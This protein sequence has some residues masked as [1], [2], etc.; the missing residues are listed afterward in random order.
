MFLLVPA[1]PCC[2]GQNPESRKMV[3]CVYFAVFFMVCVIVF[4]R[5]CLPY[6]LW[7]KCK[8]QFSVPFLSSSHSRAYYVCVLLFISF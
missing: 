1:H 5:V 2:P 8:S 6:D 4:I 7:A 3:A